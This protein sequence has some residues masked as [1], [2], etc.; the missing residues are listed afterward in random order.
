MAKLTAAGFIGLFVVCT[1]TLMAQAYPAQTAT[2]ARGAVA[3]STA[4]TTMWPPQ[5]M[6]PI[7]DRLAPQ[8]LVGTIVELTCFRKMGAG[9]I[10][11]PEQVACAKAAVADKSGVVGILTEGDGVFKLVGPQTTNFY[12]RL[13]PMLGKKVT[14]PGAEVVLSNNFDYHAFEPKSLTPAK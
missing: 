2:P 1:S 3:A 5:G 11:S 7:T 6:V 9:T 13:V 4:Q 10:S 8:T 14:A 12:A